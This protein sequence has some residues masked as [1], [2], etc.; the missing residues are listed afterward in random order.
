MGAI[1]GKETDSSYLPDWLEK[2]IESSL[3]DTEDDGPVMPLHAHVGSTPRA[4]GSS[5]RTTPVVLS[6]AAGPSPAGS[7]IRQEDGKAAWSDLDQFYA[8]VNDESTDAESDESDETSE[9]EEGTTEPEDSDD[10]ED[11]DGRTENRQ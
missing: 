2:G 6:P 10:E 8:D 5:D 7:Y 11:D 3:R 4:I 1:T 9:D